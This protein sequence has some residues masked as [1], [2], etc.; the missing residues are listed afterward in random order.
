MTHL[1]RGIIFLSYC[2]S[3]RLIYGDASH[4]KKFY[5]NPVRKEVTAV[6]KRL[7][8]M[9]MVVEELRTFQE[10]CAS[11]VQTQLQPPRSK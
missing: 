3:E 9:D 6:S 11:M 4:L 2:Y 1:E 7:G 5:V 10:S 8:K